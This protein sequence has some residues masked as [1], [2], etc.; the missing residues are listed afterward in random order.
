MP[1]IPYLAGGESATAE[2]WNTLFA[3]LDSRISTIQ[4]NRSLLADTRTWDLLIGKIFFFGE[5]T[6][7]YYNARY[8]APTLYNHQ[9]FTDAAL[10]VAHTG[11]NAA[12]KNLNL[13]AIASSYFT[14]AGL[15]FSGLLFDNSLEAHTR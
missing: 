9:P 2:R 5:S 7:P 6:A 15:P 11:F 4:N 3:E 12:K 8:G 14:A 13:G 1:A 10:N